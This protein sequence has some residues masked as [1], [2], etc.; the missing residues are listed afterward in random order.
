MLDRG[1][2][3]VLV[4][5]SN[6]FTVLETIKL[7]DPTSMAMSPNLKLLGVTNFS[8]N[9]VSFIDIDPASPRFHT[10]TTRFTAPDRTANPDTFGV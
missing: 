6:R 10:V 4:V 7:S 1:N 9:S 5:N 2:R 3:Q 8:S